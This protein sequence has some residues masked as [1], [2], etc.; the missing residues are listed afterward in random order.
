[1]LL[2]LDNGSRRPAAALNLRRLA[3]ELGERLGETVHPVSALHSSRIPADQLDGEAAL[4]LEPFLRDRVAAGDRAFGV[5]PLFFGPSRAIGQ[6]VPEVAE[7]V[8]ADLGGFEIRVAD[9]LCP[10][11]DGEPRLAEILADN[12]RKA[13]TGPP[14][15]AGD[16]DVLLVDHGSPVPAVTAVRHWLAAELE[17]RL[18]PGYR[19]AEA[20]MERR[21][22][23]EYDFNGPLLAEA[24]GGKDV[25]AGASGPRARP[26]VLAMQFISPGRHAGEGGDIAEIVAEAQAKTPGLRALISALIGE[27]PLFVDILADRA[28]ALDGVEPLVKA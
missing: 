4:T 23:A 3:R 17:R 20:V 19:V 10:L 7:R 24:L 22:G 5:V 14:M 21:D 6:F 18:G 2:L 15:A 16:A 25:G 11:P 28:A 27:H 1:M 12:V 9:P 26:V 13:L 8:S